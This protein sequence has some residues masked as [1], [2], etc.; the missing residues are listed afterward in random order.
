MKCQKGVVIFAKKRMYT[1][2]KCM[3]CKVYFFVLK[4]EWTLFSCVLAANWCTYTSEYTYI[5]MH[6]HIFIYMC[7][8]TYCV[9]RYTYASIQVCATPA[10]HPTCRGSAAKERKRERERE[11]NLFLQTLVGLHSRRH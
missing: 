8:N 7:M 3:S 2:A 9:E 6:I 11:R 10:E 1:K 5:N 4:D